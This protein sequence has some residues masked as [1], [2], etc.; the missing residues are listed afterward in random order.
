MS[1]PFEKPSG[2]KGKERPRTPVLPRRSFGLNSAE[3]DKMLDQ[4]TFGKKVKEVKQSTEIRDRQDY[5]SKIG[6]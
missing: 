2:V 1:T 4:P 6:I 3:A 5:L